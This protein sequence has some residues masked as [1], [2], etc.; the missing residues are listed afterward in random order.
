MK[1]V[2]R[3]GRKSFSLSLTIEDDMHLSIISL[4]F[5]FT[6]GSEIY[7][8]GS[9]LTKKLQFLGIAFLS[10]KFEKSGWRDDQNSN[11]SVQQHSD[12]KLKVTAAD[13]SEPIVIE[14]QKCEVK[15]HKKKDD[16]FLKQIQRH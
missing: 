14:T 9:N 10:D 6:I 7:N 4:L 12:N 8:S 15:S 13:M 5:L 2:R 1:K 3:K 16:F 11:E